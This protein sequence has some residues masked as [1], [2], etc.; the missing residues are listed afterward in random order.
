MEHLAALPRHRHL[1][2]TSA[3]PEEDP[4]APPYCT[5]SAEPPSF[6]DHP[7]PVPA[8]G[9][10]LVAGDRGA[11]RAAGPAVRVGHVVLRP[12]GRAVRAR[13]AGGRRGRALRDHRRRHAGCGSPP[14]PGWRPA[15]AAWPSSAPSP[16]PTWCRCETDVPDALVAALGLSAVAAWMAL[17]WRAPAAAGRAGARARRRRGGR[18][19]RRSAQRGCSAPGGWS[20][21]PARTR[22]SSGPARPGR[23]SWSRWSSDVDELT[24]RLARRPGER[25]TW[26]STRCSGP[27]RRPPPGCSREGGRLVNLGGASGDEAVFSSAVLRSRSAS[28]LGYTNNALTPDQRRDALTAVLRHASTGRITMAYHSQPLEAVEEGWRRQAT[29]ESSSRLVLLPARSA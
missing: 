11:A 23:T 8:A 12:A 25:S 22:R 15:T 10:S 21:W 7:D 4:C 2:P 28:V 6:A 16:T 9:Q 24:A 1:T 3:R 14:R 19:G 20:R 17:T 26:C 13:R 18:A 29:G 27:P 5:P